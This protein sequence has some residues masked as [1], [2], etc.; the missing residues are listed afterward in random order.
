MMG[1]GSEVG[2]RPGREEDRAGTGWGAA[3]W[4]GWEEGWYW[5]KVVWV[6]VA[7]GGA[8]ELIR[9]WVERRPGG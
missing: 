8:M 6:K 5:R 3:R 2:Y 9:S 1:D 7:K 4:K